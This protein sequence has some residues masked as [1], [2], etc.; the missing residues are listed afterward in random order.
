MAT[1]SRVAVASRASWAGCQPS[2]PTEEDGRDCVSGFGAQ[3][4]WGPWH[5]WALCRAL[6]RSR[7]APSL[8]WLLEGLFVNRLLTFSDVQL[9]GE[10]KGVNHKLL[11][12][13]LFLV[14]RAPAG[15]PACPCQRQRQDALPGCL[16]WGLL[17]LCHHTGRTHLWV[18]PLQ[19][20]PA[21]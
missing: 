9:G 12:D 3:K 17:H 10:E 1:C 18:R 4:H 20:P 21:G 13:A 11:C 15:P 19:L 16:L 8:P 2:F 5:A 6:L 14:P 7:G